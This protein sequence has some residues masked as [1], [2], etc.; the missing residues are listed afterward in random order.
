MW[1]G[2]RPVEDMVKDPVKYVVKD[3]VKD[4]V[5]DPVEDIV[6]FDFSISELFMAVLLTYGTLSTGRIGVL[7]EIK[8]MENMSLPS[9]ERGT[10]VYVSKDHLVSKGSMHQCLLYY[11]AQGKASHYQAMF[12]MPSSLTFQKEMVPLKL[13]KYGLYLGTKK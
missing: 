6:K 10:G 13:C 12:Q 1:E 11:S 2:S 9:T 5:K 4:M 7:V 8:D 3:P